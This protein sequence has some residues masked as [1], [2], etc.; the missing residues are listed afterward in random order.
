MSQDTPD[1]G[2][3]GY[4]QDTATG[5]GYWDVSLSDLLAELES[6]NV[7][8]AIIQSA[9]LTTDRPLRYASGHP[10]FI[11]NWEL[12]RP[13]WVAGTYGTGALSARQATVWYS[14]GA[15]WQLRAGS[16][17]SRVADATYYMGRF[18]KGI[19]GF[20]CCFTVH[21]NTYEVRA[22]VQFP[23]NGDYYHAQFSCFP[24]WTRFA[25]WESTMSATNVSDAWQLDV[26]GNVFHFVKVTF[27]LETGMYVAATV[28]DMEIDLSAYTLASGS[29]L[30]GQGLTVYLYHK[31]DSATTPDCYIDDVVIS[32]ED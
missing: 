5:A 22:G 14:K 12:A 11:E 10:I 26:G 4:S 24:D 1:F 30:S 29:G 7:K 25:V 28:D 9:T 27:D 8:T 31:G 13:G 21:A 32:E 19:M 18:P 23:Y 15:C 3:T 16:T 17:L 2:P 20:Q 6:L